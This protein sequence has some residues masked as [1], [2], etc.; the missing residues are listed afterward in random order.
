MFLESGCARMGGVCLTYGI[1]GFHPQHSIQVWWCVPETLV[2]GRMWRQ[3]DQELEV[4]LG[5]IMISRSLGL[6]ETLYNVF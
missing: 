2:P 5:Y 4:T 6:L 1:S 3:E